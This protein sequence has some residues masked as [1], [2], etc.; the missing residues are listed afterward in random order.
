MMVVCHGVLYLFSVCGEIYLEF[1]LNNMSICFESELT[2][3]SGL[4]KMIICTHTQ[5]GVVGYI[6][7]N[8]DMACSVRLSW[9]KTK[10]KYNILR[11]CSLKMERYKMNRECKE[12][13]IK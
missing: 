2:E 11:K 13:E 3:S 10:V 8:I 9:Y 7:K 4:C 12:R 6:S 1:I 5:K